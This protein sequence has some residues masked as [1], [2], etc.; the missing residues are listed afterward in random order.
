LIRSKFFSVYLLPGFIFQSLVIGGGYGTGRELVE[1]FMTK[2][3]VEG[4]L[5]MIISTVIWSVIMAIS[6]EIAR[7]AKSYDYRVFIRSFLGSAWWLYEIIYISGLILVI[8]VLGSAA[9]ELTGQFFPGMN[10]IGLLIMMLSVGIIAFYGNQLIE[11]VFSL[12]SICLYVVFLVLLVI[13]FYR[14]GEVI[15]SNL[16]WTSSSE[17][18]LR[19][20]LEY[21]A[22]N[23]GP[24]PAM[25]FIAIHF[26]NRHQALTSGMIAGLITILPGVMIYLAMLSAYPGIIHES[27][28]IDYVLAQLD[29]YYLTTAFRI[30]LF[31]TFIETGVGLIHGMNER[32]SGV[33]KEHDKDM[34]GWL[35][36]SIAIGV[37]IV[38]IFVA[39]TFGLIDLIAKGYGTLTWGYMLVFVFP[40][41]TIGLYRIFLNKST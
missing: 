6:F 36:I 16:R 10:F 31:G 21:A 14:F 40:V 26:E 39:D 37:L 30:I 20:G 1:F 18:W 3:P 32:I 35:R 9:A 25:I 15:L 29:N 7:M 22:Y 19:G 8:A 28:P 11:R 5:G 4:L 34:P 13:C 23:I 41:L 33:F 27:I 24:M 17:S 12:W 2:G 38:C